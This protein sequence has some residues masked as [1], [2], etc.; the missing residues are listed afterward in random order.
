MGLDFYDG[1]DVSN[2]IKHRQSYIPMRSPTDPT[3]FIPVAYV[4]RAAV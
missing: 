4:Q 1:G 2:H 3:S